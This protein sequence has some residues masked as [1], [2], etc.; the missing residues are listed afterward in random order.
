MKRRWI[1]QDYF[2]TFQY[3]THMSLVHLFILVYYCIHK[4][5]SIH[6]KNAPFAQKNVTIVNIFHSSIIY[7]IFS[8]DISKLCQYNISKKSNVN[9]ECAYTLQ[10]LEVLNNTQ[11]FCL[12]LS[13]IAHK[14][15]K[16]MEICRQW[17]YIYFSKSCLFK[18]LL[19]WFGSCS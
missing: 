1:A 6:H 2:D 9:R 5:F 7:F 3:S 11:R 8:F 16:I 15:I 4:F 13:S 10:F 14:K 18:Y 19:L 17:N 12:H